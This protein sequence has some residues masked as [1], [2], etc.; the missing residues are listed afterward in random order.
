MYYLNSLKTFI[1]LMF[2]TVGMLFL[3]IQPAIS[4]EAVSQP[5]KPTNEASYKWALLFQVTDDYFLTSFQGSSFSIMRNLSAT[6]HIR[7][8]LTLSGSVSD[9]DYKNNTSINRGDTRNSIYY[10]IGCYY[11]MNRLSNDSFVPYIGAGPVLSF[12]YYKQEYDDSYTNNSKSTSKNITL[13]IGAAGILG[14]EWFVKKNVS[15][16]A[17]YS[18]GLAYNYTKSESKSE[19]KNDNGQYVLMNKNEIDTNEFDFNSSSVRVGLSIY[20]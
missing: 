3:F 5:E 9:T 15:L 20:F 16:L 6:R 13:G 14:V 7:L 8:F 11:I 1:K 12:N 19:Q 10:Q 4:Q 18:G 2:I 17:E